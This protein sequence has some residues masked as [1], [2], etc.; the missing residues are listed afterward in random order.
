MTFSNAGIGMTKVLLIT[1]GNGGYTVT[2]PAGA[3]KLS[4]TY[5]DTVVNF[6][7]VTCTGSGEYYYTISQPA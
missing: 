7:Q 6:I 5:D 1:G 3:T 2:F 4:G